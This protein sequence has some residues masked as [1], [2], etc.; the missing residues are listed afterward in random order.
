MAEEDLDETDAELSYQMGGRATNSPLQRVKDFHLTMI[1]THWFT[2][3]DDSNSPESSS[4]HNSLHLS[5]L[6]TSAVNGLLKFVSHTQRTTAPLVGKPSQ[7]SQQTHMAI[8]SNTRR[9]L[10]LTRPLL[11][12]NKN[13]TL[14]GVMNN[15]VTSAGRRLLFSRICAP[16]TDVFVIQR[17]LD[18]LEFFCD[19][20]YIAEELQKCLKLCPDIERKLQR[21][22]LVSTDYC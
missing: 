22:S 19:N 3:E 17:R 6:E 15:T 13:A 12:S 1:P 11:G 2:D 4:M 21:V 7:F 9:C 16:S 20:R 18:A 14:F 8:D 10:E 5:S